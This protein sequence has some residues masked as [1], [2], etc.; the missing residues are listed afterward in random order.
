V[1][2]V[3]WQQRSAKQGVARGGCM[4]PPGPLAAVSSRAKSNSGSSKHSGGQASS[5]SAAAS[6][7]QRIDSSSSSSSSGSARA[8]Q[9]GMNLCGAEAQQGDQGRCCFSSASRA[10]QGPFAAV[11]RRAPQHMAQSSCCACSS[12]C[13]RTV[14]PTCSLR[15]CCTADRVAEP[16]TLSQAGPPTQPRLGRQGFAGSAVRGLSGYNAAQRQHLQS[17]PPH[18]CGGN[19]SRGDSSNSTVGSSC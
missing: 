13:Q 16:H 19:R 15:W 3:G 18:T 14:D 10:Q 11:P 12:S 17:Q 7:A 1:W 8:K 6:R 5:V 2:G 4:V 9:W